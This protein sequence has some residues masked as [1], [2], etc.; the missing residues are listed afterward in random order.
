MGKRQRKA[1]TPKTTTEPTT[2]SDFVPGQSS[3]PAL[4]PDVYEEDFEGT[5]ITDMHALFRKMGRTAKQ[6]ENIASAVAAQAVNVSQIPDIGEKSDR[7]LQAANETREEVIIVRT[8]QEDM[9]SRLERIERSGH[10]CR[11]SGRIAALEDSRDERKEKRKQDVEDRVK[12]QNLDK[13]VKEVKDA[14]SSML[15]MVITIIVSVLLAG[16]GSAGSAIWFIRGLKGDLQLEV[17]ARELRDKNI[18][19]QLQHLPTKEQ[20]NKRLPEKSDVERI[21]QAV[22]DGTKEGRIESGLL[23]DLWSG[24]SRSQKAH[25]CSTKRERLPRDLLI[26]CPR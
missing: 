4:P 14:R 11:Q 13:S 25:W 17:Q 12:L 6:V 19:K 22:P 20:L 23:R 16:A 1:P 7:A 2:I 26:A 18:D 5:P 24:L 21:A 3:S 8:R 9:G 10:P 15:K